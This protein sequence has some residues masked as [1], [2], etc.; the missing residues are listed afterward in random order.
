VCECQAAAASKAELRTGRA[1]WEDKLIEL[2]KARGTF[3]E[4]SA[5]KVET[6]VTLVARLQES[7]QLL[8]QG[9]GIIWRRRDPQGT[10]VPKS[11]SLRAEDGARLRKAGE[12]RRFESPRGGREVQSTIHTRGKDIAAGSGEI[13]V[14]RG[15]RTQDSGVRTLEKPTL[16]ESGNSLCGRKRDEAAQLT[17]TL[18]A[19]RLGSDQGAQDRTQATGSSTARS[20]QLDLRAQN[21]EP[22][23]LSEGPASEPLDDIRKIWP[24]SPSQL[25]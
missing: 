3:I 6:Q 14:I 9:K 24:V 22:R 18:R 20:P 23:S 19:G 2:I 16:R 13:G 15:V 21:I 10:R 25:L 1:H 8:S 4:L 11:F 17:S 12:S 5:E 7:S